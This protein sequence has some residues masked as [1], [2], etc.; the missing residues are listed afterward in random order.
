MNT[1]LEGKIAVFCSTP[2]NIIAAFALGS[3]YGANI[4]LYIINHFKNSE[5]I[6]NCI[7]KMEIFQ[8]VYYIEAEKLGIESLHK[9]GVSN[10][11]I[12]VKS[13]FQYIKN[14]LSLK[15]TVS[16]YLNIENDYANVLIS[17]NTM[18]ARFVILYFLKK[19]KA[20][21]VF[22][23]DEG[24][25]S[26]LKE[27]SH[28]SIP[29]YDVF[30][31][32]LFIGK[33]AVNYSR[34][35]L[36]YYPELYYRING[37]EETVYGM[38]LFSQDPVMKDRLKEAFDISCLELFS[39]K[40]V[41]MDTV[42]DDFVRNGWVKY[43]NQ[44]KNIIDTVGKENVI[45]KKHPRNLDE[46]PEFLTGLNQLNH[47]I[48]FE[49]YCFM[50]DISDKV[51]ITNMSTAVQTPKLFFNK[52]PTLIFLCKMLE[53]RI[54]EPGIERYFEEFSKMYQN[55]DKVFFPKDEEELKCILASFQ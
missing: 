34:T 2:F 27:N 36:V 50:E 22:Y 8:N 9:E 10:F 31:R 18:S 42:K 13:L 11:L 53:D 3:K 43:N 44:L 38:P 55:R 30:F 33:K 19:N 23:Y 16:K 14:L 52:E 41:L 4:D 48:P 51:F 47:K 1:E 6:Y 7:K 37:R 24:M 17:S 45:Y 29:K 54:F 35:K 25:G 49:Y 21:K 32:K 40:F 20:F 46:N 28:Y 26:Y 12:D 39:E 15:K 5:R